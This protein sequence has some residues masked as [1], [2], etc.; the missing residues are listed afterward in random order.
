MP[1]ADSVWLKLSLPLAALPLSW[2][3]SS[4][5]TRKGY[6][7]NWAFCRGTPCG[8]PLP[9]R[10]RWGH[11]KPGRTQGSPRRINV[12]VRGMMSFWKLKAFGA[13]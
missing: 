11:R 4:K 1:L 8:C 3:A 13:P 7:Y 10:Q 9:G 12:K 6:P 2:D 5:D